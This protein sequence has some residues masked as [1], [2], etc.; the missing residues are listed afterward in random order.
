MFNSQ[1]DL[2]VYIHHALMRPHEGTNM[3]VAFNAG[4]IVYAINNELDNWIA[5]ALGRA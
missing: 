2:V 4:L 5:E 1:P 3:A